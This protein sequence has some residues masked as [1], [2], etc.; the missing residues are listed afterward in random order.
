MP[1]TGWIA[2]VGCLL[3]LIVILVWFLAEPSLTPY[4]RWR[5]NTRWDEDF[6]LDDKGWEKWYVARQAA[7]DKLAPNVCLVH[8]APW[9]DCPCTGG[10]GVLVDP[11]PTPRMIDYFS[12]VEAA[13][14]AKCA[15]CG[16][17]FLELRTTCRN[18]GASLK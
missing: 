3:G 7:V 11:D 8:K 5:P 6:S 2:C 18:C 1:V 9:G 14:K 15:Y 10:P 12:R 13:V 16:S 4:E 17:R